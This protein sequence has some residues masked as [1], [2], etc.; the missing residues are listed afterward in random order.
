MVP[1]IIVCG[2]IYK[3]INTTNTTRIKKKQVEY[4]VKRLDLPFSF[5]FLFSLAQFCFPSLL[6]V[7]ELRFRGTSAANSSTKNS[8][9]YVVVNSTRVYFDYIKFALARRNGKY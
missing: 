5:P 8:K 4:T 2:K 1:A 6:A 3:I 7:L 9:S